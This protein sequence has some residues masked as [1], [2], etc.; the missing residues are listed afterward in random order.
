VIHHQP[1]SGVGYRPRT[2]QL[3]PLDV[4]WLREL[5][6]RPWPS[7]RLPM[8]GLD[9]ERM[10]RGLVRQHLAHVLVRAFAASQAAEN[11]ARLAA[12]E[13]AERNV[14]ERLTAAAPRRQPGAAE[15]RHRRAARRAGG[16]PGGG[17]SLGRC[18][19]NPPLPTPARRR[20][21]SKPCGRRS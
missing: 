17:G 13:A 9:E 2:V 3:L 15:R 20:R 4:A 18:P 8:A 1:T 12:M 7:P 14:D 5:R 21:S 16:L 10:L 19:P 6:D 11:A